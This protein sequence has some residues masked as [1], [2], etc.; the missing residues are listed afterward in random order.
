MH[1]RHDGCLCPRVLRRIS[2]GGQN[3]QGVGKAL[4]RVVT[5]VELR[6]APGLEYEGNGG[7]VKLHTYGID[8]TMRQSSIVE[9]VIESIVHVTRKLTF[10]DTT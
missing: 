9:C 8:G 6:D 4:A 3:W 10:V 2:G 1:W 7:S 5:L